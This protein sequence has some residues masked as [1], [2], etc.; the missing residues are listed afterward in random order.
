MWWKKQEDKQPTTIENDP[1]KES[2]GDSC[3]ASTPVEGSGK[4]EHTQLGA[5]L[6]G[7]HPQQRGTPYSSAG[8]GEVVSDGTPSTILRDMYNFFKDEGTRRSDGFSMAMGPDLHHRPPAWMEE[9]N[10]AV[11]GTLVTES[12]LRAS[13]GHWMN[14]YKRELDVAE[15]VA[16]VKKQRRFESEHD[17]LG[18][19]AWLRRKLGLAV[20]L[21]EEYAKQ[22]VEARYRIQ[23][24]V[25]KAMQGGTSEESKGSSPARATTVTEASSRG[26]HPLSASPKSELLFDGD[27]LNTAV[28]EEHRK[29]TLGTAWKVLMES[30][31]TGKP[32]AK[33]AQEYRPRVDFYGI[34]PFLDSAP[35]L[36]WFS[37]KCGIAIGLFQ[38][39]MRAFQAI[40]V[41]VQFL[42][43][44]GVGVLSI[45][46]MS[47]F[48]SVV[49]WGGN[50]AVFASAFCV[51][52][53]LT[54]AVKRRI[55]PPH[56]AEQR[57]VAHY[58]VGLAFSGATVG[59]LPWWMLSDTHLAARLAVS[60]M[61]V[62]GVLGVVVGLTM[63]RLVALNL[64]RLDATPRQLRRYEALMRREKEW[65]DKER[66]KHR[67][68]S[69]VWW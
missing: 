65:A 54:R 7:V 6:L 36:I 51:G 37:T 58:V 22:S 32:L 68:A 12:Q 1:A 17:V 46:N 56:D 25:R 34:D 48:A 26:A 57:T 60:G 63:Q 67:A 19:V 14:K 43:A 3:K 64:S 20:P 13:P 40:N 29:Q 44:S 8:G 45:L 18:S 52:D 53:R 59:A 23:D 38:G 4:F 42:K 5:R 41:D 62:G 27:A 66:A 21:D 31:R 50:T 47:V 49:K 33:V 69:V 9:K 28:A 15:A 10:V 39:T 61:F 55:L 11:D 2:R 30:V 35:S 24:E 16:E